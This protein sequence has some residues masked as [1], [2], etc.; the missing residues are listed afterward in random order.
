MIDALFLLLTTV[1]IAY[2]PFSVVMTNKNWKERGLKDSIQA[3]PFYAVA[4]MNV[5]AYWLDAMGWLSS[6]LTMMLVLIGMHISRK[7]PLTAEVPQ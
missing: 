5:F 4:V 1:V 3:L 7:V 2:L 6:V